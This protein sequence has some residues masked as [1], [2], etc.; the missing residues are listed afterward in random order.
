LYQI[1]TVGIEDIW[2]SA[3]SSVTSSTSI[4]TNLTSEFS[5]DSFS[6]TGHNTLHGQHHVA[7]KSAIIIQSVSCRML[8]N[9]SFEF[10]V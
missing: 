7:K 10:I 6:I 2:Y 5:F 8:S 1:N 9:S 3:A 4:L